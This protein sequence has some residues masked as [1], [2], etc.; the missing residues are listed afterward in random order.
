MIHAARRRARL[1]ALIASAVVLGVAPPAGAAQQWLPPFDLAPADE[2]VTQPGA[3]FGPGGS[4]TFVWATSSSDGNAA[5]AQARRP[6]GGAVAAGAPPASDPG[7][8]EPVVASAPDGTVY[9][10]WTSVDPA[11]FGEGAVTVARLAP[12]GR[13]A[14]QQVVS[15]GDDASTPDL[16]VAPDGTVG[17]A[18]VASDAAD[19]GT[20]RAAVGSLGGFTVRSVSVG[21]NNAGDPAVAFDASGALR[22]AWSRLDSSEQGRIKIAMMTRAGQ[23]SGPTIV[24][25]AT[26]DAGE[27]D[28][29]TDPAFGVAVAWTEVDAAE[30]GVVRLSLQTPGG[31]FPPGQ[32][33]PGGG[34]GSSPHLAVA[35]GGRLRLAW[36]STDSAE[37]G[38]AFVATV[39]GGVLAPVPVN[40]SGGDNVT[41]VD[42]AYAPSGDGVAVWRRALSADDENAAD[43]RAAGF[44]AAGPQLLDL[45]IPAAARVGAPASFSVQPVDV[46]SAVSGV[47]WQFG[48]GAQGGGAQTSHTYSAPASPVHVTVQ[49]TDAL[50][51]ASAAD[52]DVTVT[53]AN[54]TPAPTPAPSPEPSRP[55]AP[56]TLSGLAADFTCIRYLGVTGNARASFAFTLS[57]AATVTIRVQRRRESAPRTTCP[58]RRVPGQPGHYADAVTVTVPASAGTGRAEVGP[59]GE[60]VRAGASRHV[61]TVVR[62]DLRRGRRKLSLGRITQAEALPPGTYIARVSAQAADGRR[63]AELLVKFWVLDR[64]R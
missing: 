51:N 21:D 18:W 12:D 1:G 57:E 64:R 2:G 38:T 52:G 25:S 40:V 48:D 13:V 16:A 39:D 26:A 62:R 43:A 59:P 47:T 20:V 56:L 53:P 3:A 27:P 6:P 49:A 22:V 55:A 63:S 24:S 17:V 29:A 58:V 23:V 50:G 10:A 37:A 41:H 45:A 4:L 30:N 9:A 15:G 14:Q 34:D 42:L 32:V 54:S 46:W 31:A 5:I 61:R 28:V 11:R 44:D 36:V 8:S 7:V 33:A 19:Q 60:L 35:P